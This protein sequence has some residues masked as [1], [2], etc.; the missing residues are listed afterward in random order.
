M[1]VRI[2]VVG[3]GFMG[4][5]WA[6]ALAQHPGAR[7]DVV[8]DIDETRARATGEELGCRWSTDPG[9]TAVDPALD[10]V[11]V[12]TPD[13]LHEEV[14]VAAAGA[15]RAVAVEK[16][17]AHDVAAG[18]RMLDAAAAAGVPVLA[19]HIL[20][21]EP[22]YAAIRAAI[23]AGR[24][25]AVQAI[26][27]ERIGVVGD[28]DVLQGR[29]SIPLYYGTHE[30]DLARWYAGDVATVAATK[31]SGVLR[32][33]GY[34]I[35]DLYSVSLRFTSGAHGTSMLGWSLPTATAGAG[36]TGFTV[37]GEHGYLR[38]EQGGTGLVAM[39]GSGPFSVDTW[40]DAQLHGRAVGALANEVDHFVRVVRGDAEP[41]C[42][43]EDGLAAV[44]TALA[45]ARA[46]EENRI[47][48]VQ[49][50]GS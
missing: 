50:E 14:T 5:R 9:G 10:G 30:M 39:D 44:R 2:G 42:T 15:G 6:R 48:A 46:A 36:L 27:S 41:V 12:C 19:A 34:D 8:C 49:E 28:Q 35:D 4:G 13:H 21:F 38:V 40:Y 3:L 11:V 22:R 33:A 25:G 26:R 18:R 16:P 37:I 1:T 24:I 45:I 29:V 17:F 20:R 31:S 43:G 7:L 23:D 32:A 47:V